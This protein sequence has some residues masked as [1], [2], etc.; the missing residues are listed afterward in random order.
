MASMAYFGVVV[1]RR[2]AIV[3]DADSGR[4]GE[5]GFSRRVWT[6][7]ARYRLGS[8]IRLGGGAGV[9]SLRYEPDS[10]GEAHTLRRA[11][12]VHAAAGVEIVQ[13]TFFAMD[14]QA[15]ISTVK[16]GQLRVT[17]PAILLGYEVWLRL[18]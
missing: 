14:L 17:H 9:G 11:F 6:L 3:F 5:S 7:G 15:R 2:I 10:Q 13:W 16:Y 12:A 18:P 8:R 4:T 1:T